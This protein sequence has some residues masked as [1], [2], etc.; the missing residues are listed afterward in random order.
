MNLFTKVSGPNFRLGIVVSEKIKSHFLDVPMACNACFSEQMDLS[1]PKNFREEE[2]FVVQVLMDDKGG[3]VNNLELVYE[4]NLHVFEGMEGAE[5]GDY[6]IFDGAST[7]FALC[8][9]LLK[10]CGHKT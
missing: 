5:K 7:Q 9:A 8:S 10:F 6:T 4:P 1:D 3:V 2:F